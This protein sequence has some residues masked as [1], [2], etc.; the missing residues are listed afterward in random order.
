MECRKG[1]RDIATVSVVET[2]HV[3]AHPEYFT[4]HDGKPRRGSF[5]PSSLTESTGTGLIDLVIKDLV[6]LIAQLRMRVNIQMGGRIYGQDL[7]QDQKIFNSLP[8]K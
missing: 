7:E 5:P 3:L 2:A 1:I 4:E 6:P 8:L